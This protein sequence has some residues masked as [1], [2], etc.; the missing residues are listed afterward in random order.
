MRGSTEFVIR[1]RRLVLCTWL[2]LFILGVAAASNLGSLLSNRFSVPGADSERGLNLLRSKFHERSDGAFTLV[3]QSTGGR[4]DQAAVQAAA[5]RG[6]SVLAN[7][8][9]GPV[10]PAGG[11]V[12]YVQLDTSLENAKASDK[13][14]AVRQAAGAVPGARLYVT[15]F[16]AINHDTQPL[17]S[18]GPGA[19]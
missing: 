16:P 3:A 11:G 4:L 17:Y 7:G 9:A 18:Q 1:H 12:D 5:Q 19:W 15:G 14:A 8:K 13:T 10:L 2:I 6:A